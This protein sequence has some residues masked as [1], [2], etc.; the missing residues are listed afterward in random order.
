MAN[1]HQIV[2]SGPHKVIALHGW[3]ASAASWSPM[4]DYLDGETFTYAFMD[5]RGYGGARRMAGEYTAAEVAADTLA[6]ADE[7]GWERFSLIGHSM[8]G[9]YIERVLVDAPER[10]EKLV[11]ISPVPASGFP[12]DDAG[13]ALFD[14]AADSPDNR[15][16]I[17]DFTT[18]NRNSGV[19][20]DRMV[21][22]S[23]NTSDRDAFAAY[24]PAWGKVDFHEE[25]TAT[26][27][28]AE[29][30]VK[31]II[32]EHDPAL[33]AELMIGTWLKYHPKAELETLANAGHYPMFE[34]P[35][36]LAT[37]IEAFLRKE[38]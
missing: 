36:A 20:L 35:V 25:V 6:L 13:W 7:L 9:V 29:V 8:G 33:N 34:T 1:S 24:L 23:L 16:A 2:G 17:I 21:Q 28:A 26:P 32:G 12:F 18:G 10:V 15:R 30:P 38:G 27:R 3:F 4:V 31:V 14:G 5:A 11:G 37:S 19:W 22:N